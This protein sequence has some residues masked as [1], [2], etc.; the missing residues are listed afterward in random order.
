MK[1]NIQDLPDINRRIQNIINETHNGN[2]RKFSLSMG[3][4]DSSK[5]NRLFNKDK[6]SGEYPMPSSDIILLISNTFNY[7]TDFIMKGITNEE[8]HVNNIEINKKDVN[9]NNNVVIG[10]DNENTNIGN[11]NDM[12]E[13][14]KE[15]QK[16]I[17]ELIE[18]VKNVRTN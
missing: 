15:Q 17:T 4:P 5:I 12:F 13:I 18:L 7:T 1:Q 11:N 14:F 8:K 3:L 10:D 2:V 16:Q 9:G 6:R